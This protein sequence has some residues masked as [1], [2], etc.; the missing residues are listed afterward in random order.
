MTVAALLYVPYLG[1]QLLATGPQDQTL[2]FVIRT[3]VI[4]MIGL[5]VK[6]LIGAP[7]IWLASEHYLGRSATA[8]D[9]LANVYRR[10][11]RLALALMMQ[12]MIVAVGFLFLIIPGVYLAAQTFAVE[13][14]IVI[15]GATIGGAFTRSELLSKELKMHILGATFLATII[16][17]VFAGGLSIIGL[18]I[19]N[20]LLT[21]LLQALVMIVAFPILPITTA[22]VYYDTR[23]RR[24]GFDVEWMA[25]TTAAPPS[26]A[27]RGA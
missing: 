14:L 25:G 12:G 7:L 4:A 9:A 16:Y 8:L 13:P 17:W 11:P 1:L 24:E 18:A 26:P 21:Q 2:A 27:M 22:V 6:F 5:F 19:G 3:G 10:L 23:I 15:D 20:Q